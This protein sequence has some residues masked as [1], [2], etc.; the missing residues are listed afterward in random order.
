MD[1]STRGAAPEDWTSQGGDQTIASYG[2]KPM[3]EA[4][5][6]FLNKAHRWLEVDGRVFV[7]GGFDPKKPLKEQSIRRLCWD[8]E[9]VS[10]AYKA[11][12]SGESCKIGTY[13]EVFVGH[14]PTLVYGADKPL[15]FCNIWMLDTGAGWS[16]RLT[17]MDVE[18]KEYWQSDPTPELY[19]GQGRTGRRH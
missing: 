13:N 11:A 17:I 18:T 4:H 15:H 5:M 6:D 10:L 3:P 9:V 16:G 1:W 19:G 7:H 14:T 2:G 12:M 8:R